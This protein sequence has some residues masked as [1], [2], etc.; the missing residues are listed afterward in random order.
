MECFIDLVNKPNKSEAEIMLV[1]S[2]VI[3]SSHPGYR[4]FPPERIFELI[5]QSAT[6]AGW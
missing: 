2:I 3:L 4:P 1:E 6:Q 5:R